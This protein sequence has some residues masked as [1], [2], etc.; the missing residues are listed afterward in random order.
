MELHMNPFRIPISSLALMLCALTVRAELLCWMIDQD[1]ST[2]VEFVF[3]QVCVKGE[4]GVALPNGVVGG[5]QLPYPVL[6]NADG[7]SGYSTRGE[8]GQ[9]VSYESEMGEYAQSG[10]S[11][12]IE[13]YGE[14]G[15]VVG[16]SDA[17]GYDLLIGNIRRDVGEMPPP[18]SDWSIHAVP[19]PTSGLLTL[20]GLALLAL[21]RKRNIDKPLIEEESFVAS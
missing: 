3:A 7:T 20:W 1:E 4:S 5:E 13:L 15:L 2:G 14:S 11:F 6:A 19:E 9:L 12:Y 8:D 21:R 17:V 10:Q 16:R 18:Y